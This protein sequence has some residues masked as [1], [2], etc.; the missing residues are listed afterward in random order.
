MNRLDFEM[1]EGAY[2]ADP[3]EAPSLS[4]S[5]AK[6]LVSE[7]PA[8]AYN[9]HPKLGGDPWEASAS[10]DLGTVAHSLTLGVPDKRIVVAVDENGEVAKDFRRKPVQELRDRAVAAGKICVLDK[11]ISRAREMSASWLRWLQR[12][13]ITLEGRAEVSMFWE[14]T[15]SDG[16]IVQCR[17]R[18]DL[19]ELTS[20][21]LITDLKTCR[22]AHP[23]SVRSAIEEYGYH[24]QEAAYRSGLAKVFPELAG[25]IRYRWLFGETRKPYVLQPY[26]PAG[27]MRW[28]GEVLWKQAIDLWALCIR[29]GNWAAYSE[30]EIL[31]EASPWEL[32]H[33]ESFGMEE[34]DTHGTAA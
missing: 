23:K 33:A 28:A 5:I 32:Q 21:A 30:D 1:G 27:S 4:A 17:G 15:S 12:Y 9:A 16:T 26:K 20:S 11:E 22:R 8:I 13:K 29:T 3:C 10:M 19:L 14:E 2:H 6:L 7:C 25:R 31:V 18:M 24:I 34:E